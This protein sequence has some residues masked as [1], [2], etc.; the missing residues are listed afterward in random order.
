MIAPR[1]DDR[2]LSAR[3]GGAADVHP[4]AELLDPLADGTQPE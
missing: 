1:D 4:A 3:S 2:Q